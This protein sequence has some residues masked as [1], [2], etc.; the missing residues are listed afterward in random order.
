MMNH[1]PIA[2]ADEA[3]ELIACPRCDALYNIREPAF[4]ERAVCSRCHAV[5]IAPK[6]GAGMRLIA[7][8]VSVVILVVAAT[9]FPFLS[10]KAGGVANSASIL[11]AAYSFRGGFF[12]FLAAAVAALIVFVPVLRACLIIYVLVPIVM[13]RPPARY[14]RKAFRLSEDLRPWSMAEI[15]AIG[16]AVA[17]VKVADLADVDFGP[18]FYMFAALVVLVVAQDSYMCRYSVWKALRK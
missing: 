15:F 12:A 17:L 4:G 1:P 18:A 16:C 6:Q 7:I 14:S 10:I 2:A 8:A 11:D 3:R 9:I 5:L 13:D